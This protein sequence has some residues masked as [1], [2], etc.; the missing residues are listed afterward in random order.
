MKKRIYAFLLFLMVFLMT[1]CKKEVSSLSETERSYKI[2][3][4]NS[5]MM[6]LAPVDYVT[7]SV[8][9]DALVQ[10]LMSQ[11]LNVPNDVDCQVAL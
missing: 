7:E 4:L 8:D 6:K 11:F 5:S 2:Y 9:K 3:Y 10:E 1:G